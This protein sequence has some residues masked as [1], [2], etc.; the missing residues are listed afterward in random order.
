MFNLD[1]RKVAGRVTIRI[2]EAKIKAIK[3]VAHGHKQS[4]SEYLEEIITKHLKELKDEY[5]K[6]QH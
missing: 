4:I 3:Y 6:R 5:D 2:P 1:H